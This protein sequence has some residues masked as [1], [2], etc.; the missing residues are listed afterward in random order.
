MV[1]MSISGV[2]MYFRDGWLDGLQNRLHTQLIENYGNHS[3]N[4][5]Y[6]TFSE[7]MNF[8]QHKVGISFIIGLTLLDAPLQ[9]TSATDST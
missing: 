6:L 5:K 8:I 3:A 1:E 7:T 4:D 9:P 2:T